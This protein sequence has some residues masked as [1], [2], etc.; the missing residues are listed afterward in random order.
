[1]KVIA[2]RFITWLMGLT[3]LMRYFVVAVLFHVMLLA[4][5]GSI[6]IVAILPKI[7]AAF[8]A[9]V[10]P[11]AR[12]EEPDP[13]AAYRDFEYNGPTLGGGGGTGGKGPGGTPTASG[14]PEDYKAHILTDQARAATPS[15]VSEVIGVVSEAATAMARPSGG[16]EGIGPQV[17][18]LGELKIGTGGIKGPGGG[19]LG[20]RM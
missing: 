7:V 4:I 9:P 6:K 1:M 3:R 19:L 14:L 15:S 5:L 18:G 10:L 16:P 2:N 17:T 20:A 12:E 8:D 11:P 13:F